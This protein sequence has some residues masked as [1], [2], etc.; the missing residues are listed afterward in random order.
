MVAGTR[1]QDHKADKVPENRGTG[2]RVISRSK[3]QEIK[4]QGHKVDKDLTRDPGHK[5]GKVQDHKVTARRTRDPGHKADRVQGNR[6][7]GHRVDKDPIR[8]RHLMHQK[9]INLNKKRYRISSV[10]LLRISVA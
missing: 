2:H 4:G 7:T 6:E 10:F 5:A 8:V 1:D 9:K 3:D